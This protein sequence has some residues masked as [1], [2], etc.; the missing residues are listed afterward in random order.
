[1]MGRAVAFVAL[2]MATC[3]NAF[4]A[5]LPRVA[6]PFRPVASTT[7]LGASTSDF[8]NG[9]TLELD[10]V[11][12]RIVEFLHV[13]PGKGAAFVRTKL[14]NLLNGNTVEKTF[15]AGAKVEL[16]DVSKSSMQFT[17]EDGDNFMFMDMTSFEEC[18]VPKDVVS[19][20]KFLKEGT[21][22]QVMQWSGK[23]IDVELPNSMTFVVAETD[24]NF[25]GN[26]VQGGTKPATLETGAIVQVPMF[27][28]QGE[29]IVV[30]TVD[31]KYSSRASS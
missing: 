27:I 25:K 8:K 18:A 28:E 3:C 29:E 26:T 2:A 9:L 23:V 21:E 1:M 4:H 19:K 10:G 12:L 20:S 22:C 15:N 11:P 6:S 16:A 24:P 17:Y 31:E 30:N 14:K 5:P 7:A 13:K